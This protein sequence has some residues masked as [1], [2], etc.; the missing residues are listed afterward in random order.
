MAPRTLV[1]SVVAEC[2]AATC[3]Y[4]QELNCTAHEIKVSRA[5]SQPVCETYRQRK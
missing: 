1:K 5:Q 2:K 3:V 4:N